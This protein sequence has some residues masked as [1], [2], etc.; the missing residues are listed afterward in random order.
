MDTPAFLPD[1]T[2][3]QVAVRLQ[4]GAQLGATTVPLV[5]TPIGSGNWQLP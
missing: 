3:V 5:E 2:Y 4:I 1:G